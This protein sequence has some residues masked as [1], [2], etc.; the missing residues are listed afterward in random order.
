L[1]NVLKKLLRWNVLFVVKW[2]HQP[3]M[4]HLHVTSTQQ[5]AELLPRHL[6]PRSKPIKLGD[7][8]E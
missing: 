4:K 7:L 2:L 3:L 6:D 5:P 8:G 1:T